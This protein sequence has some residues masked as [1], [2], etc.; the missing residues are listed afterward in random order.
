MAYGGEGRKQG[1][2]IGGH[3]T[4]KVGDDIGLNESG[5]SGIRSKPVFWSQVA[6]TLG[7]FRCSKG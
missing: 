7:L 1:D 2:C 6:R 5:G 4:I 3:H